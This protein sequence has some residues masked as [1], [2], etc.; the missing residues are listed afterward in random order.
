MARKRTC[1][2]LGPELVAEGEAVPVMINPPMPALSPLRTSMRVERLMVCAAGAGVDVA[3]GVVVGEGIGVVVAVAVEVGEGVGVG[4]IVPASIIR[5]QS[6]SPALLFPDGLN[7]R[8]P[9]L[10]SPVPMTV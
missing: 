8:V 10:G 1:L 7:I 3:V 2:P 4:G 6:F 9:V 5:T